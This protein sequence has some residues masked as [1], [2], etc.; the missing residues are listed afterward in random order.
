MDLDASGTR[1]A[2]LVDQATRYSGWEVVHLSILCFLGVSFDIY[3]ELGQVL[4]VLE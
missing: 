2:G 3:L 1:S 4:L